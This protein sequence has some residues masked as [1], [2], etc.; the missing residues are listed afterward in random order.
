MSVNDYGSS[1]REL[2]MKLTELASILGSELQFGKTVYGGWHASLTGVEVM[3]NGFL[4]DAVGFGRTKREAQQALVIAV[5]G[6]RVTK[7]AYTKQRYE[8]EVPETLKA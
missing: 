5:R 3:D 1:V 8:M 6:R 2:K 7:G 4:R